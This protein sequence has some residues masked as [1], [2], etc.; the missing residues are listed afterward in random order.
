MSIPN[1]GRLVFLSFHT[2]CTGPVHVE[3]TYR[4]LPINANLAVD[5]LSVCDDELSLCPNSL[6][7]TKIRVFVSSSKFD[8]DAK[9]GEAVVVVLSSWDGVVCSVVDDED[10]ALSIISGHSKKNIETLTSVDHKQMTFR[11]K[12]TIVWLSRNDKE[13][14]QRISSI[15]IED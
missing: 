7:N 9:E 15:Q 2:H 14:L 6:S 1:N 5:K 4:F 13:Y 12:K 8:N 11:T 10:N 3:H